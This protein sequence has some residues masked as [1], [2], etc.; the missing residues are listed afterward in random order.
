MVDAIITTLSMYEQKYCYDSSFDAFMYKIMEDNKIPQ[1]QKE[2]FF[3]FANMLIVGLNLD[4]FANI[5]SEDELKNRI[6]PSNISS[7]MTAFHTISL[8]SMYLV[9]GES[10]FEEELKQFIKNMHHHTWNHIHTKIPSL[11]HSIQY[12]SWSGTTPSDTF[13]EVIA[14]SIKKLRFRSND[15]MSFYGNTRFVDGLRKAKSFEIVDNV[16][17]SPF[18]VKVGKLNVKHSSTL[19]SNK[20]EIDIFQTDCADGEFVIGKTPNENTGMQ[21]MVKFMPV[22]EYDVGIEIKDIP[23]NPIT[24]NYVKTNITYK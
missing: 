18:I 7:E 23:G 20:M 9:D 24:N 14:E 13:A 22:L 16:F 3:K 17:P 4:A 10:R 1:E 12:Y 2:N 15:K 6:R 19:L 5:I 11:A 21:L 8:K